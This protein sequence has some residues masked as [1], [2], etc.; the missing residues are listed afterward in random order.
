MLDNLRETW[1]I[2]YPP[3]LTTVASRLGD[4]D[5]LPA[6]SREEQQWLSSVSTFTHMQPVDSTADCHNVSCRRLHRLCHCIGLDIL[7]ENIPAAIESLWR[8][9]TCKAT[10]V[11]DMSMGASSHVEG[12]YRLDCSCSLRKFFFDHHTMQSLT[13]SHKRRDGTRCDLDQD[14]INLVPVVRGRPC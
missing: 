5:S 9:P 12:Q 10:V 11:A 13:R 8:T 14:L 6:T 3:T 7:L 2:R 4:T 1:C